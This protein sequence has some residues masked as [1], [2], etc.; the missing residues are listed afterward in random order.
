MAKLWRNYG[1]IM[2]KR[3]SEAMS[4]RMV[5]RTPNIEE[6]IA[7]E[8]HSKPLPNHCEAGRKA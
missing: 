3:M 7:M 6:I 2:A 5:E 1:E 4:E 8:S